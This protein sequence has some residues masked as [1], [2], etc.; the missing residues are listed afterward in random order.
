MKIDYPTEILKVIFERSL[1]DPDQSNHLDESNRT[2]SVQNLRLVCRS[3]KT[4]ADETSSLWSVIVLGKNLPFHS[5]DICLTRS[6]GRPLELHFHMDTIDADYLGRAA[7]ILKPHYDRISLL[8]IYMPSSNSL[9][10]IFPPGSTIIFPKL[11]RLEVNGHSIASS[12]T[13]ANIGN[14]VIPQVKYL[15]MASDTENIWGGIS[16]THLENLEFLEVRGMQMP[17]LRF[18]TERAPRLRTLKYYVDPY[19]NIEDDEYDIWL[20]IRTTG[21][22]FVFEELEKLELHRGVGSTTLLDSLSICKFPRLKSLVINKT[23]SGTSDG[24]I[25]LHRIQAV[26]DAPNIVN[27]WLGGISCRGEELAEFVK[28]FPKLRNLAIGAVEELSGNDFLQTLVTVIGVHSCPGF[29]RLLIFNTRISG[30]DLERFIEMELSLSRRGLSS[31][32]TVFVA[33]LF[34]DCDAY[35]SMD[36]LC[37]S[38]GDIIQY[39]GWRTISRFLDVCETESGVRYP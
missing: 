15:A 29:Q 10:P 7:G 38:Y 6:S 32:S 22:V 31:F 24:Y 36:T 20:D 1:P 11:S 13:S 33:G 4:I 27:I 28:A 23:V 17:L 14:I 21:K 3:W 26:I 16:Q 5:I 25:E 30:S 9:L 34:S 37:A 39:G 18:I 19:A 2:D 12:P 8:S 35:T